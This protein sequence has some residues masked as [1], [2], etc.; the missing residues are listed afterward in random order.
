MKI[1]FVVWLLCRAR[2]SRGW[3]SIWWRSGIVWHINKR[4]ECLT[5]DDNHGAYFRLHRVTVVLI[6][7]IW[8]SMNESLSKQCGSSDQIPI[9][10]LMR[11]SHRTYLS[12]SGSWWQRDLDD[13]CQNSFLIGHYT[14]KGTYWS[15]RSGQRGSS[16]CRQQGWG[17]NTMPCKVTSPGMIQPTRCI[18]VSHPSKTYFRSLDPLPHDANCSDWKS[19]SLPIL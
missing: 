5:P 18:L 6:I 15:L 8:N 3:T 1:V 9:S 12:R 10:V 19:W 7:A 2:W 13:C 14:S 4:S 17:N 11:I 16:A